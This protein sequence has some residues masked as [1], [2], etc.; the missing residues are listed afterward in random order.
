MNGVERERGGGGG[1]ARNHFDIDQLLLESL[2]F[3]ADERITASGFFFFLLSMK[4]RGSSSPQITRRPPIVFFVRITI[5][6]III[7][8]APEGG[9]TKKR[10]TEVV[11]RKKTRKIKGNGATCSDRVPRMVSKWKR[12]GTVSRSPHIDVSKRMRNHHRSRSVTEWRA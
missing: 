5:K 12:N 8:N 9:I 7:K 4:E 11:G 3:R 1:G 2:S 10:T 6:V